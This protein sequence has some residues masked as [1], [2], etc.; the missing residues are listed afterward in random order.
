MR[1]CDTNALIDEVILT[2]QFRLIYIP[3]SNPL[4]ITRNHMYGYI[5]TS[6]QPSLKMQIQTISL[7]LKH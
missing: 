2:D 1:E 3:K 4:G 6:Q 5:P 7:E